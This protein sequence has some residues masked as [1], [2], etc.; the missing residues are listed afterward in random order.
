MAVLPEPNVTAVTMKNDN[1]RIALDITEEW[2]KISENDMAMGCVIVRNE[3]LKENREAVEEFLDEYEDSIEHVNENVK[4]AS[5][6]VE[7]FGI[8]ASAA[9]AEKAIPNCN[10]CFIDGDE[11]K[12]VLEGFYKVL[13]EAQPKSVGGKLPEVDFYLDED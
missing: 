10:I 9:A 8:M 6:L 3:F 12:A 13:F 7:K 1:I 11:M 5:L 2:D 4:E